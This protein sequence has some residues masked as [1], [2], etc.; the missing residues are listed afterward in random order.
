MGPKKRKK[1]EKKS[2]Y[3][4]SFVSFFSFFFSFSLSLPLSPALHLSEEH[5]PPATFPN[6]KMSS[7]AIKRTHDSLSEAPASSPTIGSSSSSSSSSA[8][9]TSSLGRHTRPFGSNHPQMLYS[10][11]HTSFGTPTKKP[12]ANDETQ[13]SPPTSP[14]HVSSSSSSSSSSPQR[15]VPVVRRPSST[16]VSPFQPESC[17]G[18]PKSIFF[19]FL[20]THGFSLFFFFFFF[21]FFCFFFFFLQPLTWIT[22]RDFSPD[23]RSPRC[24]G[25][26]ARRMPRT[27]PL[28][29]LPCHQNRSLR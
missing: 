27:A 17:N 25:R 13:T 23:L 18:L 12:R 15:K 29:F 21:F 22:W 6:P 20:F 14:S 28:P 8:T 4:V 2:R 5:P 9:A 19:G 11:S 7:C 3:N 24:I 16:T 26:L 10:D 1:R